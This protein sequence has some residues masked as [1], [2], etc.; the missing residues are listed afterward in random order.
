MKLNILKRAGLEV[1]DEDIATAAVYSI[2]EKVSL[3]SEIPEW[4]HYFFK[5]DSPY[6]PDVIAKIRGKEENEALLQAAATALNWDAEYES[7]D[8]PR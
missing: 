7:K 4:V 3:L 2:R 5:D 8:D 6:E 1:A